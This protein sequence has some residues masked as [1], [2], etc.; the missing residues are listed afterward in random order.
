MQCPRL[1]FLTCTLSFSLNYF[2]YNWGRDFMCWIKFDWLNYITVLFRTINLMA[3]C[4][5]Y[6]KNANESA[7]C[8]P[9]RPLEPKIQFMKIKG[10][11]D[12]GLWKMKVFKMPCSLANTILFT[13]TISPLTLVSF[14]SSVSLCG[15]I[16]NKF[17]FRFSSPVAS[18]VCSGAFHQWCFSSQEWGE[19]V[20]LNLPTCT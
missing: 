20:D 10:A 16:H 7:S 19:W 18:F 6:A 1:F 17:D 8:R 13:I 2:F 11:L 14:Q 4:V 15:R 3:Q 12:S 9:K 5:L